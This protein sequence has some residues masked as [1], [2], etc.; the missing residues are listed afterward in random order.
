[1]YGKTNRGRLVGA[2]RQ[3]RSTWIKDMKA[4]MRRV[5]PKE[6]LELEKKIKKE[7]E[8]LELIAE[9]KGLKLSKVLYGVTADGATT[10]EVMLRIEIVNGEEKKKVDLNVEKFFRLLMKGISA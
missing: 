4:P 3:T 8:K 2:E 5:P 1:M 7:K 10:K 9:W 6:F